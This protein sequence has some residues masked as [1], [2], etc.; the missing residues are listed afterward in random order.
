[1]SCGGVVEGKVR[2][3][4]VDESGDVVGDDCGGGSVRVISV[5]YAS[6]FSRVY[7]N[8]HYKIVEDGQMCGRRIAA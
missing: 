3:G 1:V 8:C 2:V 7:E 6:M 4:L 5:L